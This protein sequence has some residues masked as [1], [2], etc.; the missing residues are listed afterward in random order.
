MCPLFVQWTCI[1]YH[2]GITTQQKSHVKEKMK[3]DQ[4][5]RGHGCQLNPKL[6]RPYSGLRQYDSSSYSKTYFRITRSNT[7][8]G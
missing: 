8:D 2:K 3:G 4:S 7:I 1:F 5:V 6:R